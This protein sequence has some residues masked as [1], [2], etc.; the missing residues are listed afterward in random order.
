MRKRDQK[1]R[2]RKETERWEGGRGGV[3]GGQSHPPPQPGPSSCPCS[4][5]LGVASP[6][7]PTA[8]LPS[9]ST[10]PP[11]CDQSPC[12]TGHAGP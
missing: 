2:E 12:K 8:S 4:C 3:V 11:P 7:S 10:H 9:L 6:S 1:K 5:H